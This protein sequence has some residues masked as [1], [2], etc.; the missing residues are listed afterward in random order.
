MSDF[1]YSDVKSPVQISA[2]IS[3]WVKFNAFSG[4]V[5]FLATSND[6]ELHGQQIYSECIAGK[7]GAILLPTDAQLLAAAQS[8][9]IALLSTACQT[10]ITAGFTSSA[11]GTAYTYPSK[12][13]DQANLSASVVSSLIPGNASGWTTPLWCVSAGAWA[14]VPHTATQTQVVGQDC[15][16]VVLAFMAKN[17]TLAGQVM[18]ATT[19]AAVKS[20]VW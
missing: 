20:V 7:W 4:Y 5:Q 11:L 19:V 2:G 18:A 9:Q 3:C 1:T 17:L 16:V 12:P 13:T 14:M 8:T 10:A 6:P 15:K